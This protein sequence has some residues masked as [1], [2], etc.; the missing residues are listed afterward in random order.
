MILLVY[1]S[2]SLSYYLPYA[3]I[4]LCST[5]TH[6]VFILHLTTHSTTSADSIQL[7][8]PTLFCYHTTFICCLIFF[9]HLDCSSELL[10]TYITRSIFIPPSTRSFIMPYRSPQNSII[11]FAFLS[12]SI[13]SPS[14]FTN[15]TLLSFSSLPFLSL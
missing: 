15:F 14:S 1:N 12:S 2:L 7:A 4:Q 6:L 9:H 10:L 11:C 13:V 8:L 5:S 3:S